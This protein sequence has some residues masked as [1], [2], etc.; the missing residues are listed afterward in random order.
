MPNLDNQIKVNVIRA[1]AAVSGEAESSSPLSIYMYIAGLIVSLSGMYAA[2][3]A[4]SDA[5]LALILRA[6]VVCGYCVSYGLRRSRIDLRLYQAPLL[7]LFAAVMYFVATTAPDVSSATSSEGLSRP[8]QI[9]MLVIWIAVLQSF[10]LCADSA[11]LF[12]C[13][14]SMALIGIM[15]SGTPDTE[16]QY[17]FYVFL[18]GATFLM[19][20]EN[21]LRTRTGMAQHNRS[22]VRLDNRLYR[23]EIVLVG[24]CI[25]GTMLLATLI[26][27]PIE[28]V[29]KGAH[30]GQP[31]G[32]LQTESSQNT[33]R[34]LHSANVH[35]DE[36]ST[37][38]IGTGPRTESNVDLLAITSKTFIPY[39][40][41]ATYDY[42]S[43]QEFENRLHGQRV[44]CRS[45]VVGQD[46]V[47]D[48]RG[49]SGAP[50]PIMHK[51]NEYDFDPYAMEAGTGRMDGAS[52]AVS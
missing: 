37:M 47:S 39:L 21:H 45:T 15:S 48:F 14:P 32:W 2:T 38:Q 16:V 19:V 12:A 27:T 6:L 18:A 7:V 10:T 35:V 29:G 13:V 52:E 8:Y 28:I 49:D 40:R 33:N 20:H 25:V 41:G 3:Y 31:T 1:P 23:G 42:Y 30:T 22:T 50:T 24:C 17:A 36:S 44:L 26:A 46:V 51:P 34:L 4:M 5:N 11:I 43:G 9:Q